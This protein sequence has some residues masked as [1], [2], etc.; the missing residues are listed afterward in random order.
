MVLQSHY[1]ERSWTQ[2]DHESLVERLLLTNMKVALSGYDNTCYKK[3][4][5]H[6]WKKLFLKEV[7][8]SSSTVS[9]RRSDEYLWINFEIPSS[10]E[11]QVCEVDYSAW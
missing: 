3:L 6:G 8:V 2:A 4:E 1:G 11:E 9:K 5:E 10:L 7:F